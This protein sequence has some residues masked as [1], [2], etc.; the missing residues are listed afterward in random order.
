MFTAESSFT[1]KNMLDRKL[2]DS[3]SFLLCELHLYPPEITIHT[4][5]C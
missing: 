2:C 4:R 1:L 3:V 5:M